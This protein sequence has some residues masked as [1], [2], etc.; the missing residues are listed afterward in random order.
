MEGGYTGGLDGADTADMNDEGD[1][2]D[3]ED[4]IPPNEED[5]H[6]GDVLLRVALQIGGRPMDFHGSQKGDYDESLVASIDRS[7]ASK[8]VALLKFAYTNGT[9]HA[10]HC[11]GDG[12]GKIGMTIVVTVRKHW[13]AEVNKKGSIQR[14]REMGIYLANRRERSP[15]PSS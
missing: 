3:D 9:A 1:A 14:L 11:A 8:G 4:D 7:G 5:H 10:Y 2:H 15:T 13:D 12:D 6:V